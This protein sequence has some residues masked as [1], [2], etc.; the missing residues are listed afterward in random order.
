MMACLRRS[1]GVFLFIYD[2][3]AL[4]EQ[5]LRPGFLVVLTYDLANEA[6][7]RQ[8]NTVPRTFQAIDGGCISDPHRREKM[9][10]NFLGSTH[11]P[12]QSGR[13]GHAG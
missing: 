3:N 6:R 2:N 10:A 8:L 12:T 7:L 5:T 4:I 1:C 11:P 13:A 9:L